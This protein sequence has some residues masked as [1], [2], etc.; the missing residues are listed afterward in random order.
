MHGQFIKSKEHAISY[1]KYIGKDTFL[2]G[3]Q[4]YT[5]YLTLENEYLIYKTIKFKIDYSS[6][7]KNIKII[8][9]SIKQDLLINLN[10]SLNFIKA[11]KKNE[12]NSII[13]KNQNFIF[14]KPVRHY[15]NNA[16]KNKDEDLANIKAVN[17]VEAFNKL[18]STFDPKEKEEFKFAELKKGKLNNPKPEISEEQRKYIVQA[19]AANENKDYENALVL[20]RKAIEINPYSYPAAYFNMA[21]I[22]G[23]MEN[24]Y[25]AVYAMKQYLIVAPDAED[26]RKAQDKIYEWEL[27]IKTI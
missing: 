5:V 15:K 19:N 8:N 23:T 12:I 6:G 22:H 21:L 3:N 13:Y 27:N 7:Y 2:I 24:Y 18:K 4:Y 10:D 9:E 16:A 1:L 20:F 11:I 26:A 25:Q 17:F 14:L